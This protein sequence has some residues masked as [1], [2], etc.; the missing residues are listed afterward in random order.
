MRTNFS[1]L[2]AVLLLAGC[3]GTP[4]NVDNAALLKSERDDKQ[5]E[6]DMR[7]PDMSAAISALNNGQPMVA[8]ALLLGLTQ[9]YPLAGKPWVNVGLINFRRGELERAQ[10]A[11]EKALKLQPEI[12]AADYLLG[13]VAHKKND[14]PKAL[15]YYLAALEKNQQHAHSH[16]NVALLY[17]TYYQDL[18]KAVFHY[19]RYLEL[20]TSDDEATLSWVKEL[21][22]Q[23]V[24]K[25]GD[26]AS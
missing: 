26:D 19:R 1:W 17:D 23:F 5:A 11:A 24:P 18:E 10:Q 21:E 20:S 22:S 12:A 25:G 7:D 13:L 4:N 15:K 3:A 8:K 9:R 6:I 2:M 14:V 16:Y